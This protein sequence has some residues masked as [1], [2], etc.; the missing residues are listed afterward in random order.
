MLTL[1]LVL[2]EPG[3]EQLLE[4]QQRRLANRTGPA[5]PVRRQVRPRGLEEPWRV[6]RAPGLRAARAPER[7]TRPPERS[8]RPAPSV[9]PSVPARLDRASRESPGRGPRANLDSA[10]SRCTDGGRWNNRIVFA[11]ALLRLFPTRLA[12]SSWARLKSSIN[13]VYAAALPMRSSPV[14]AGS[15]RAPAPVR[16]VVRPSPV[17]APGW[18][19][20]PR[21]SPAPQ[22]RSPAIS[23]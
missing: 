6:P 15:R 22:R 13:W 7:P 1:T 5:E 23:S 11:T 9:R 14:D 12:T 16:D 2:F 17:P 4:L 21:G 8:N 10:I 3:R 19:P 20:D 18:S